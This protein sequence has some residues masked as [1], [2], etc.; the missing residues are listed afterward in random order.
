MADMVSNQ[1]LLALLITLITLL[2]LAASL[3]TILRL[4]KSRR[5]TS[6]TAPLLP[7]H[8]QLN[9]SPVM[10]HHAF[11]INTDTVR[12]TTTVSGLQVPEI[13]ITFPDEE[14]LVDEAGNRRSRTV[15]VQ[16]GESGAAYVRSPPVYGREDGFE[17]MKV[18][19][20]G[21]LKENVREVPAAAA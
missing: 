2:L 7:T 16:V 20:L 14:N 10:R 12:S 18:E 15:I 11:A 6:S 3:Y 21:G 5:V 8:A 19:E 17:E 4:I 9:S 13:R 1:L